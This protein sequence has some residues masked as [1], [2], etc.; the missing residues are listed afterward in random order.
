M[1]EGKNDAGALSSAPQVE[2]LADQLTACAD[3]LHQRIMQGINGHHGPF[4][5]AEQALSRTMLDDEILLRQRADGLYADAANY[6]VKAL[7]KSQQALMALT[8]DA[9]K[10]LAHI[11]RIANAAGLV[12]GLLMLAGAVATGQAAP[13]VTAIERISKQ[14]KLL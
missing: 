2:A 14:V 12:G 9:A 7:G 3:A 11:N 10:K 13:I 1:I 8:A 6:T 4:S 5:D